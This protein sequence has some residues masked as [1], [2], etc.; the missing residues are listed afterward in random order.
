MFDITLFITLMP[1]TVHYVCKVLNFWSSSQIV[2]LGDFVNAVHMYVKLTSVSQ[3][4]I[5]SL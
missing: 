1:V 3:G 4:Q 5:S 2:E